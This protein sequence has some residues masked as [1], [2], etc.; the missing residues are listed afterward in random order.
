MNA[1]TETEQIEQIKKLWLEYGSA[2]IIGVV[3]ALIIGFSWRHWQQSREEMLEHVS[4]R[5]EQLL[6][7]VVNGN[8]DAVELA[9]NRLIKRYPHTPYTQLAAL[10]L[11]RQDVYQ[12]KY[13]DAEDKLDWVMKRGDSAPLRQIARIR[14]ARVLLADK[15]PQRALDLLKDSNDKAYDA[16]VWETRGD[17][18]VALGN[19]A[20]ARVAYNKALKI[21]PGIAVTQPLLQ[22]KLNEL[23]DIT[24]TGT[25][26]K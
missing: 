22:M 18:L 7:N 25:A 15:Q 1:Y 9:A 11:A 21:L 17:I 20:D 10:Q 13:A 4:M 12:G 26:T 24:T 16:V 19:V 5:Y 8:T 3:I 2:I 6:T 14:E 23:P